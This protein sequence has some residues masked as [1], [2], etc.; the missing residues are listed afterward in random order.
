M[1]LY[2]KVLT[3]DKHALEAAGEVAKALHTPSELLAITTDTAHLA[4]SP[5]PRA[6]NSKTPQ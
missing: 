4:Q 5:S 1:R 3:A 6:G 2:Q